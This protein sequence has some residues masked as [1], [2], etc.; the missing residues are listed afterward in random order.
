M[1][2][3]HS[4]N[5][6]RHKSFHPLTGQNLEKIEKKYAEVENKEA[7]AADRKATLRRERDDDLIAELEDASA[8]ITA[9]K[10][11]RI[12]WMFAAE[13]N[14]VVAPTTTTAM[15]TN[16]SSAMSTTR[17]AVSSSTLLSS[18]TT[19]TTTAATTTG[20]VTTGAVTT[21]EAQQTRQ[22]IERLRKLKNDPLS[23]VR[24]HRDDVV[25]SAARRV[26]G[27]GGA[28]ADGANSSSAAA[29]SAGNDIQMRLQA[30]LNARAAGTA[31][32]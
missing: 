25:A 2:A 26:G 23:K 29:S 8:G 4:K 7:Q 24:Q 1:Y 32:R 17:A 14:A 3:A 11:P 31:Q 16:S 5:I 19:A 27:G 22:E 12:D 10:G 6:N 15:S 21:A 13:K 28:S 9:T 18:S 30:L 20:A